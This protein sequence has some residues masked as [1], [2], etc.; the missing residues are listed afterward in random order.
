[1]VFLSAWPS[2][3]VET[4][5]ESAAPIRETMAASVMTTPNILSGSGLGMIVVLDRVVAGDEHVG[6][7]RRREQAVL[8]NAGVAPSSAARPARSS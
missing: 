2:G 5:K 7:Q 4:V 8:D 6:D 1:M 3:M